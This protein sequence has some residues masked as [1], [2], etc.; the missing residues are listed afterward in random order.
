[1]RTIIILIFCLVFTNNSF[2]Q[3]HGHKGHNH[4]HHQQYHKNAHH[5]KHGY[6]YHGKHHNH[7]TVRRWDAH[8]NCWI[9]WDG[10]YRQWYYWCHPHQR[11]YPLTYCPYG[12]YRFNEQSLPEENIP[13]PPPPQ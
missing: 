3:H 9:Y 6:Y 11:Y 12:R 13:D 2:A 10:Y 8:R 4:S 7:W 5:F 1:M